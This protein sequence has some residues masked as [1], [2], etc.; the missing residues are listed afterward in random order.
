MLKGKEYVQLLEQEHMR[1]RDREKIQETLI[2]QQ[3]KE[4]YD[5]TKELFDIQ[6]QAIKNKNDRF[7]LYTNIKKT[8]VYECLNMLL[9]KSL[10]STLE[11]SHY[12][13]IKRNLIV[14]FIEENGVDNILNSF[15]GKTYML[16]EFYRNINKYVTILTEA[17]KQC[18]KEE[19][20]V[21]DVDP[22][23]KND[24]FVDMDN[25][26]TED[27]ANTIKTRVTTAVNEFI[28]QNT[29]DQIEIKEIIQQTQ[30]KVSQL[31]AN[32][33]DTVRESYENISKQ[34]IN[35]IRSSRVK[36]VLECMI[37]NIATNVIKNETL[38]ESYMINDKLD[39]DKIV[40]GATIMYTFLEM[41]NT[42]Q[43]KNIDESYIE[44][45]LNN[46]NK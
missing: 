27:V 25:D 34:K 1:I 41:L 12:D 45:I 38:K 11:S 8:L 40:E 31:P 7:K 39:M 5:T 15:K 43:I 30:D 28:D 3:N 16:S 23:V 29:K 20:N 19:D 36:N 24:F 44:G 13:S 46:L 32:T 9:N 10:N 14:N 42:A 37:T 4:Y 18:T 2:K 26:D 22:D 21:I 33:S 17:K 6:E 35:K